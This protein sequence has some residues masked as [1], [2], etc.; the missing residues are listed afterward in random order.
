MGFFKKIIFHVL[1][2]TGVFWGIENY[3]FPEKFSISGG[4]EAYLFVAI[5]FGLLN[6]TIKPILK[7]LTFPIKILTLGISSLFLN[8][9]LLWSWK[10]FINF[11][12]INRIE[13]TIIDFQTYLLVGI[14]LAIANAVL[15]WLEKK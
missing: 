15:H 3:V 11:L 12:E 14:L 1:A 4:F 9:G 2:T 13:I 8:A 6:A 5:I 7:I 10:E